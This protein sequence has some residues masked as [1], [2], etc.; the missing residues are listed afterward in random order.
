MKNTQRKEAM[1]TGKITGFLSI[2][3]LLMGFLILTLSVAKYGDAALVAGAAA[4]AGAFVLFA[5][6]TIQ[7]CLGEITRMLGEISQKLESLESD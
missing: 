3:S 2:A 6:A 7:Y 1:I 5:I 4:L